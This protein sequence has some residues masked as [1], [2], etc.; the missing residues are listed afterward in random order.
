MMDEPTEDER[1]AEVA[2]LREALAQERTRVAIAEQ[3]LRESE[4]RLE[5]A[6][7][8]QDLLAALWSCEL[9]NPLHALV[10]ALH[11]LKQPHMPPEDSRRAF[12]VMERQ[13]SNVSRVYEDLMDLM[14]LSRGR[15]PPTQRREPIA[16]AVLA[17]ADASLRAIEA[18]E[19]TLAL[20]VPDEPIFVDGD[21]RWLVR[22]FATLLESAAEHGQP[23]GR[24]RLE[25]E[26]QADEVVVT[27]EPMDTRI[28]V[29]TLSW[30][31]N[32]GRWELALAKARIEG[33]GGSITVHGDELDE[34]SWIVVRL[35]VAPAKRRAHLRVPFR[36]PVIAGPG[37]RLRGWPL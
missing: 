15:R 35:P 21:E 28:S 11:V 34:R 36:S 12:H 7:R 18:R 31:S 22:T 27:V 32:E 6:A 13:V 3:A 24:V 9:R 1:R 19:L 2:A 5:E 37:L 29:E 23:G 26:R 8:K 30:T 10:T 17:A 20:V 16:V 25:V 33:L 4:A 14:M